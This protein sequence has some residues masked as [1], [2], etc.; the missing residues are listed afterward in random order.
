MLSKIVRPLEGGNKRQYS[1]GEIVDTTAWPKEALLQ[2]QRYIEPAPEGATV[3]T[4]D[5]DGG[6]ETAAGG[7]H[8]SDGAVDSA[9]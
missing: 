3:P 4:E 1:P 9:V 2:K 5:A 7:Q 6:Q 8:V